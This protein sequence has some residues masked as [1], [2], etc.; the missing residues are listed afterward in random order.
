M[1]P[2]SQT[3]DKPI[4]CVGFAFL[5]ILSGVLIAV[6]Y[7]MLIENAFSSSWTVHRHTE[8]DWIEMNS[9]GT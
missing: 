1:S 3:S 9:Q 8:Q 5:P 7:H 4:L 6:F 2:A